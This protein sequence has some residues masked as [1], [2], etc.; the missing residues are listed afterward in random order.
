MARILVVGTDA[1]VRRNLTLLLRSGHEVREAADANEAM[2]ALWREAIDVVLVDGAMGLGGTGLCGTIRRSWPDVHVV[3]IADQPG[4]APAADPGSTDAHS[5]LKRPVDAAQL[6]R[7]V[8]DAAEGQQ[9]VASPAP[10]HE[11]RPDTSVA[12]LAG[13]RGN[14]AGSGCTGL[15]ILVV[16]DQPMLARSLVRL[17]AGND[18]DTALGGREAI[19]MLEEKPY[20]VVLCDL[21]MPHV[22]GIDVYEHLKSCRLNPPERLVFMSGGAATERAHAFLNAVPNQKLNKPL[23]LQALRQALDATVRAASRS[24]AAE[25]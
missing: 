14:L 15:R 22:D 11:V 12:P 6:L 1:S 20:D 16:D 13:P 18:V 2:A 4:A 19:A 8:R 10:A 21:T 3:M 25:R 17:L 5:W 23:S 7:M 9:F 24:P